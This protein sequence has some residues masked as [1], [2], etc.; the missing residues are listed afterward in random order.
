MDRNATIHLP[1]FLFSESSARV[2]ILTARRRTTQLF[3]FST[4]EFER[5][6][7]WRSEDILL[8]IGDSCFFVWSQTSYEA[9]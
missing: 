6:F 7:E 4:S 2:L 3:V 1:R 9:I 5:H 8:V